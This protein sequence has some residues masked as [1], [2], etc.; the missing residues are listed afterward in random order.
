MGCGAC[1]V[2]CLGMCKP[3]SRW[4]GSAVQACQLAAHTCKPQAS[5][6]AAA[7]PGKKAIHRYSLTIFLYPPESRWQ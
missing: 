4:K 2:G 6:A 1:Q 5:I 3:N 7:V